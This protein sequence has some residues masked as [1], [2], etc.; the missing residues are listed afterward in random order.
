MPILFHGLKTSLHDV[1]YQFEDYS[2]FMNGLFLLTDH[3]IMITQLLF[4]L[5]PVNTNSEQLQV[6][7]ASLVSSLHSVNTY[8]GL[9]YTRIIKTV[10]IWSQVL[11]LK[12]SL[13]INNKLGPNFTFKNV[14]ILKFNSY[15]PLFWSQF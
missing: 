14:L 15:F 3:M 4:C 12:S 5:R 2:M 11:V 6:Y 10:E 8:K 13:I 7:F 9:G 1:K